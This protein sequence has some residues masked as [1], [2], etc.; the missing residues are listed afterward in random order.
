MNEVF[1]LID[2][3]R[4]DRR[5]FLKKISAESWGKEDFG[6][7][8]EGTMSNGI[9]IAVKRLDGL[10]H[11]I[12]SFQTEVK[13]VCGI[14]HVNL[15]IETEKRKIET[16]MRGTRGYLAPEW[17]NSVIT[18]KVYVYAFGIVLLEVLCG[19]KNLDPS[20]AYEDVHL[21]TVFERKVDQ[22]QL[23]DMVDK[24]NEEMQ[25]H[26]EI[27]TE[28][29]SIAAWCLQGDFTKRTSI[30]LV[31]KAL[32]GLYYIESNPP[33]YY[34]ASSSPDSIHFS[35]DGQ[36]LTALQE[37][38]TSPAQFIKLQPDGH[39]GYTNGMRKH[40]N[41]KSYLIFPFHME[42]TVQRVSVAV[43]LVVELERLILTVEKILQGEKS[44]SGKKDK[45]ITIDLQ[46]AKN[47]KE[48]GKEVNTGYQIPGEVGGLFQYRVEF[49]LVGVHHLY[50]AS[51]DFMDR[52]LLVA[53]SIFAAGAYDDDVGDA[54]E[55]IYSGRGGNV[56][57]KVKI[58]EDQKLVN[59]RG[60][61]GTM[62]FMFKLV[63]I[64]G[65]S[66][67]TRREVQLSKSY[68]VWHGV[69]LHDITEGKELLPITAVNTIDGEKPPPFKFIKK[70][71]YPVGFHPASPKGCDCIGRCFDPK[72]CSCAV[73]NG[74]EILYN[75]GKAIVEIKPLYYGFHE[76]GLKVSAIAAQG[77][78]K[79]TYSVLN[80]SKHMVATQGDLVLADP[81][82]H[83]DFSFVDKNNGLLNLFM[84]EEEDLKVAQERNIS[85]LIEK[86]DIV[87]T[88]SHY[89]VL[90]SYTGL[91][92]IRIAAL[93]SRYT[94][95]EP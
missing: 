95:L 58:P 26:K 64:P 5:V 87:L 83:R 45:I 21:L 23:M 67:V 59:E 73:N 60:K 62:V 35:F 4:T 1:S 89:V 57:G 49:V 3:E 33:K 37:S 53:T 77:L 65:Q 78:L 54:H 46:T 36:T 19:R 10:G 71:M 39:Y 15:L 55:L 75:R 79:R 47:V 63:S 52:G 41:W 80:N 28:M 14:H 16:R 34:Y 38:R 69:C 29:M 88:Q 72:R 66:E 24:N 40:L 51:I 22:Q 25:M 50:E 20:Q 86:V 9:K 82:I 42:G 74:G 32:E 31:V 48:K 13:I 91:P 68:E 84:S 27:V 18:E 56:V 12:E 8:Y 70:M 11:V 17:L 90:L 94:L 81:F 6:A 30:S 44:E 2:D 76:D 92:A 43:L 61:H 7:V 85:L 93:L